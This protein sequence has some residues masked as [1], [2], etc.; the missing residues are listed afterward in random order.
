MEELEIKVNGLCEAY[1]AAN[2]A[3]DWELVI[4]LSKQI[5]ACIDEMN[6]NEINITFH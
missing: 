1:D 6:Q 3:K 5:E 4:K 2:L